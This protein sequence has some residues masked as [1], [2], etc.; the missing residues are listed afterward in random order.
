M[1]SFSKSFLIIFL[2]FV[3]GLA[4]Q[5]VAIRSADTG[6]YISIISYE[7][8]ETN[9]MGLNK[10]DTLFLGLD[11]AVCKANS[12]FLLFYIQKVDCR[13]TTE[14]VRRSDIMRSKTS[15]KLQP[16]KPLPAKTKNDQ[17]IQ[18]E[19]VSFSV[20]AKNYVKKNY[21]SY[22]DYVAG[23][24]E[25]VA[26]E[27]EGLKFENTIFYDTL[28]KF[29][30]I[31]GYVDTTDKIT[32]GNTALVKLDFEVDK[33]FEHL[34][35]GFMAIELNVKVKLLDAW[36]NKSSYEKQFSVKSNIGF[37]VSSFETHKRM[38]SNA[39]ENLLCDVMVDPDLRPRFV[40]ME[41]SMLE[42]SAKWNVINVV[43]KVTEAPSIETAAE[44]V[45]T[46]KLK[47][48]HGSGCVVSKDGYIITNYHVIEGADS[49]NIE[50]IFNE[51]NKKKC[52]VIRSNP[53]YDLA[54]LKIDTTV[55][56]ILKV[57]LNKAI[58]LGSDVYAIGTP[59]DIA[60]GQSIS[61]GI[62]SGKR[63]IEN[64]IFLQSDVSVNRGN[65]GGAMTNKDGALIGVVSAKLIGV[66]VE[67]VG[68][69]IPTYYIEDALKIK[70]DQEIPVPV[71]VSVPVPPVIKKKK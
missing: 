42:T 45:V 33:I 70:F 60:L 28:N 58:K 69:A 11:K 59:S 9:W 41:K 55:S 1:N 36:G 37:S 7:K 12:E 68:F 53:F 66:G 18:V 13:N 46:I 6:N 64:K 39:L 15:F 31:N 40:N 48:G 22:D 43:N 63:T 32:F 2:S 5:K 25:G 47:K 20:D 35:G 54:L 14:L 4:A 50:A 8:F 71:P 27:T 57:D 10:P 61:K 62:I 67:G 24:V 29:L 65:S 3:S 26:K 51:G 49:N 30:T 17:Y 34:F 44:S 56:S 23:R 16:L 21:E 19:K 52:K 38:I